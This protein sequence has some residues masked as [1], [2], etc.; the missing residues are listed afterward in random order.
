M[1]TFLSRTRSRLR[2]ALEHRMLSSGSKEASVVSI[3]RSG[4]IGTRSSLISSEL[5]ANI[6]IDQRKLRSTVGTTS[7]AAATVVGD[8]TPLLGLIQASILGRGPLS[9]AEYM[10]LALSHPTYG[11]YNV[12]EA[13]GA[14]GDFTTSPEVSQLF[15]DLLGLWVISTLNN[16]NNKLDGPWS[17][18][19]IGPGRGTLMHDVLRVIARF[20]AASK[21]LASV[22]LIETSPRMRDIQ[23]R[24]LGV[25]L[26]P[27]DASR[28]LNGVCGAGT[29]FPGLK[30]EWY[31][32]LAHVPR[33]TS[34][35]ILAHELFDALPAH[36]FVRRVEG[37]REIL[38][39]VDDDASR[40]RSTESLGPSAGVARGLR[41][42]IA[43]GPTPGSVAF[44]SWLAS[45][46]GRQHS[47]RTRPATWGDGSVGDIAEF[48][49]ASLALAVEIAQRVASQRGAALIVDYGREGAE[50]FS[51]RGI[52]GHRFVDFLSNPGSVDLSADVDF[53][54]LSIM[55][56]TVDSAAAIGPVSQG[57]FLQ[58]LG[59]AARLTRAV[60]ATPAERDRLCAEATRL[61]HPDEM[62]AIYKVLAI[63]HADACKG[64]PGFGDT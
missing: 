23:A 45:A 13:I 8:A 4:L 22:R 36:Q 56:S 59:L 40:E 11:Y 58:R 12:R 16:L 46:E 24:T 47:L 26:A 7:G 15:G 29:P 17:L 27:P 6:S 2:A 38:V 34:P 21:A 18:S 62:G 44:T 35:V 55:A 60:H 19:E 43:S 25:D 37:W 1:Q 30:V 20:P 5:S 49:P 31:D 50:N 33:D 48:S 63:V 64:T 28:G 52:A 14:R 10:R 53:A 39:D 57:E 51:L 3:D 42:V 41:N 61:A 32:E 9:V 54:A